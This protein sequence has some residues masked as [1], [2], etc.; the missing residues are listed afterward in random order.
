M[1]SFNT[2]GSS[3]TSI[4][5]TLLQ[6]VVV[7]VTIAYV[8]D[9]YLTTIR[10]VSSKAETQEF[11]VASGARNIGEFRYFTRRF[12]ITTIRNDTEVVLYCLLDI[13]YWVGG[14]F[15]VY[16]LIG[17]ELAL[18][19]AWETFWSYQ[20]GDGEGCERSW[21]MLLD[22][23]ERTWFE[24]LGGLPRTVHLELSRF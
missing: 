11:Y 16:G 4:R 24:R 23:E 19:S 1:V 8:Y 5:K 12:S 20:D 14:V 17:L 7:L 2:I 9:V 3:S 15:I 18:V 22:E 10:M 21:S 6:F 13:Y